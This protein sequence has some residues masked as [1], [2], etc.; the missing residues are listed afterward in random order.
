M[1]S[2]RAR[3]VRTESLFGIA[4]MSNG[5]TGCF[6]LLI[7]GLYYY[8]FFSFFFP[9]LVYR[10]APDMHAGSSRCPRRK[11]IACRVV[12]TCRLETYDC[13]DRKLRSAI[14]DIYVLRQKKGT[15]ANMGPICKRIRAFFS[16]RLKRHSPGCGSR[17]FR[18]RRP[19]A[20]R[21]RVP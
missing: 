18:R 13:A 3:V 8:F 5:D 21:H 10:N 11:S 7:F 12:R 19:L 1:D 17:L 2:R 16:D 14:G 6:R 9:A 4:P 15:S 20:F